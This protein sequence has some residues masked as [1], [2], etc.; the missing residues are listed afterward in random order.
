MS[1]EKMIATLEATL[2]PE[3]PSIVINTK[4]YIYCLMATDA[5][6]KTWKEASMTLPDFSFEEKEIP[7]GK[8]LMLLIEEITRSLPNYD[9]TLPVAKNEGEIGI[10]IEKLKSG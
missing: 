8:A 1:K 6:L 10:I 9:S 7:A 2:K 3:L 5:E 4:D